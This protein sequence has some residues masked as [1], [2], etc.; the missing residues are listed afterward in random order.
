MLSLILFLLVKHIDTI[1]ERLKREKINVE[2]CLRLTEAVSKSDKDS[3][4]IQQ[5]FETLFD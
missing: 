2:I 1:V 4:K 5:V 3:R